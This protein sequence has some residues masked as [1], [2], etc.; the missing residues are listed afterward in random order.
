M[1]KPFVFTGLIFLILIVSC[2]KESR[3]VHVTKPI[4]AG[5]V[6]KTNFAYKEY[7]LPVQ[8]KVYKDTGI[9]PVLYTDTHLP[10]LLL[11][12][13]EPDFDNVVTFSAYHTVEWGSKYYTNSKFSVV[14]VSGSSNLQL[15][16]KPLHEGDS[17]SNS[18]EWV[19]WFAITTNDTAY[20]KVSIYDS[21]IDPSHTVPYT[22]NLWT[23]KSY[24]ATRVINSSDT[25]FGWFQ[26]QS[27]EDSATVSIFRYGY[28]E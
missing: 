4:T 8:I 2:N 9:Y 16:P 20:W 17:I 23:T 22:G 3:T 13:Y 27:D 26:L 12:K 28:Q 5:A 11:V 15:C 19:S 6:S 14:K 10:N 1:K 7:T 18:L 25:T 24:L 21:N